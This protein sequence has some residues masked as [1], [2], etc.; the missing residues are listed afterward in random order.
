MSKSEQVSGS[1]SQ[2]KEHSSVSDKEH[3]VPLYN[4]HI[5]V[6]GIDERKLVRKIDLRLI[7]WLSFLYLLSF[8]DRTS[9]GNARVSFQSR[10]SLYMMWLDNMCALLSQLY[11]LEVDLHLTDNQYL[12]ALTIF[13]FSYSMFEVYP[14]LIGHFFNPCFLQF[15]T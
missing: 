4:A 8:L 15:G 2:D 14:Y 13:Y 7:P 3:H 5:D 9:I 6:S 1:L 12:I 11:S 10:V